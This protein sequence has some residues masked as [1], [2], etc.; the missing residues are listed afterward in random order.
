[1]SYDF[2]ESMFSGQ[3]GEGCVKGCVCRRSTGVGLK[4]ESVMMKQSND[5]LR[6]LLLGLTRMPSRTSLCA[7]AAAPCPLPG[8][9]TTG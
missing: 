9:G 2:F 3:G 1:M 8:I 5:A 6:F 7:G 4:T